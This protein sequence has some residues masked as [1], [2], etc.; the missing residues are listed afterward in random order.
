MHKIRCSCNIIL[1][2]IYHA[3]RLW[4]YK[5]FPFSFK[6]YLSSKSSN[7]IIF[8]ILEDYTVT[9]MNVHT[10]LLFIFLH[11]TL[12]SA[13]TDGCHC[14]NET[15]S[16]CSCYCHLENSLLS[17]DGNRENLTRSFFPIESIPTEF[18]VIKYKYEGKSTS[19]TWYWGAQ[20]SYFVQ[21]FEIFQY[22][23]LFFGGNTLNLRTRDLELT[24][25]PECEPL[26]PGNE[27]M[28]SL[29]LRVSSKN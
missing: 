4:T 27:N 21:P 2:H 5:A 24:L 11:I 26:E 29:T 15:A 18:V 14:A 25:A 28:K 13:Q 17:S 6:L 20:A 7:L 19:K 16:D 10:F 22:T 3:I 9:A 8:T 1:V 23:S 12:I